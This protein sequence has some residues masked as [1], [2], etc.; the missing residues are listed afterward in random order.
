MAY[1]LVLIKVISIKIWQG[2]LAKSLKSIE[3]IKFSTFFKL[4]L[5]PQLFLIKGF[6]S[7]YY[8]NFFLITKVAKEVKSFIYL[9]SN[10]Y[11][12]NI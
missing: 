6:I 1:T 5:G 2:L 8:L 9:P 3:K 12:F 7:K 11:M 4:L 10:S